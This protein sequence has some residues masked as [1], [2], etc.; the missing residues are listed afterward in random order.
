MF[1]NNEEIK[2]NSQESKILIFLPPFISFWVSSILECSSRTFL[3][4][5][6]ISKIGINKFFLLKIL[7]I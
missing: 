5:N 2:L 6:L 7:D 1:L 4:V 3:I